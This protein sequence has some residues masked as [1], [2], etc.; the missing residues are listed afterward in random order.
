M[1]R[2]YFVIMQPNVLDQPVLR[3]QYRLG[4]GE[5]AGV[6]GKP[7]ITDVLVR[8]VNGK[9]TAK[10]IQWLIS[11]SGVVEPTQAEMNDGSLNDIDSIKDQMDGGY[12]FT[13][14]MLNQGQDEG[15][16]YWYP[17][18]EQMSQLNSALAIQHEW[19]LPS[20]LQEVEKCEGVDPHIIQDLRNI[21]Q[22]AKDF[23]K[24]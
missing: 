22:N 20:L 21:V 23:F 14:W 18:Y 13:V 3:P 16:Y 2:H 7:Q 17:T 6:K 12:A 10:S 1:P 19:D 9:R 15:Y 8:E 24:K 5:I 11:E 4:S